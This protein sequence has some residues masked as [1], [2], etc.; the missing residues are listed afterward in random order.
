MQTRRRNALSGALIALLATLSAAAVSAGCGSGGASGEMPEYATEVREIPRVRSM[1]LLADDLPEGRKELTFAVTPFLSDDAMR[2]AFVPISA[3]ISERLGVP[4]RF[5]LA[6]GY[7]DLIE[8]VER[9]EVDIVQLS[10]L[11]YVIAKRQIPGL[12]L[13]GSSLS[14]AS[15][16]YA[17]FIIARS[18]MGPNWLRRMRRR[19]RLRFAFVDTRSASGF[20]FP[21]AALTRMGV[22]P[23]RDLEVIFSGS[24]DASIELLLAGKVEAAAVSSGT[25]NL[26]ARGEVIGSG[27]LRILHK[28]GNIPYDALCTVPAI[29]ESGARKI[30]AAFGSL[31]TR[32]HRGREVL[33]QARGQTG[34][35]AADEGRYA[36]VRAVS[37]KVQTVRWRKWKVGHDSATEVDRRAGV[38]M[39]ANRAPG[40]VTPTSRATP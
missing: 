4:V 35:V 20:L 29:P 2:K 21:Y 1:K 3:Y 13:L 32:N 17:S 12:R 26:Q 8:I 23:E 16:T 5:R 37:E 6:R 30:A 22:D 15:A 39:F 14:F 31:N 27:N 10:P 9:S 24:H 38:P 33:K 25:L 40:A 19:P 28:A 18:D 34:W 11:S 36:Q 7:K